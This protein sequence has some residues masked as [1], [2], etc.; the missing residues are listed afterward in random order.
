[1]ELCTLKDVLNAT[2]TFTVCHCVCIWIYLLLYVFF[3]QDSTTYLSI[4]IH[5][6]MHTSVFHIL[7]M[8]KYADVVFFV[9][10]TG[11]FIICHILGEH[12]HLFYYQKITACDI[13]YS[14]K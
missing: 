9:Y 13:L 4:A 5:T 8:S 6:V 1:M 10:N 12:E 3:L 7:G 2:F 11:I 14:V